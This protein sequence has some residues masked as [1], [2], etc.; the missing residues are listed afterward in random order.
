MNQTSDTVIKVSNI[1]KDFKLPHEKST[2]IKSAFVNI[3]KGK[4]NRSISVQ[5]ALKDISFE[6]RKGEFFGIVGRNGSGKSTLLK[7]LAG[8]YQPSRGS[9]SSNGKLVPFIELGVGFN[10][11]LSGRE[12]VYLNGSLLGFNKSQIDSMYNNIVEFAE[13]EKFMDQKLKNYS[14]GMQVRL[15]F[16]MAVRAEAD[17]LLVDEVLAVGDADFQRK[18]F[19]YFRE[20][21]KNKKTVVFV[22]H[23]MNSV[24]EYCDKAL[25]INDSIVTTIG[26]PRRVAT[27]YQKMFI[28]NDSVKEAQE[29]IDLDGKRWGTR[30]AEY[31]D[32]NANIKGDYLRVNANIRARQDLADIYIGVHVSAQDG[33]E[34]MATNN[35]LIGEPDIKKI[36][37]GD[38]VNI[39]WNILNIFND[40]TYHVSLTM[41]DDAVGTLDWYTDAQKFTVKR[42]QRSTTNVFPPT[43]LTVREVL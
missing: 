19:K 23:D 14:S 27:E 20:L 1:Y 5:H 33:A 17:I 32:I 39:E 2:T 30:G 15:A 43:N 35:R 25:L 26:S 22:T 11:E 7:I 3:L 24:I 41:I 28:E 21:K 13:L 31:V 40:G 16:S 29:E 10:P 37:K 36:K 8:I 42:E 18:C 12:N 34:I 9:V 38:V 4:R 6:I